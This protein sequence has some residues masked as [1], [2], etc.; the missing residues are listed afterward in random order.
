M[1]IE[2]HTMQ[3]RVV[4]IA[5]AKRRYERLLGRAANF[6]PGGHIAEWELYPNCWLQVVEG[7]A[8]PGSN[9]IRFGLTRLR[10][11]APFRTAQLGNRDDWGGS[12]RSAP[13]RAVSGSPCL[14]RVD[15]NPANSRLFRRHRAQ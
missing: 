3:C 6:V 12:C 2:T 5:A 7:D 4:N 15:Q 9:R 8:N 13:H 1:K 10:R 14:R 11:F